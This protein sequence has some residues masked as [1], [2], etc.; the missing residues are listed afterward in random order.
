[1]RI[2]T[3]NLAGRWTPAHAA[4]LT[5]LGCDALLLPEVRHDVALPG[6]RQH[7]SVLEMAPGRHWASIVARNLEA[8]PDPHGASAAARVGVLILCSSVLPWRSA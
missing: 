4:L 5:G 1:M 2:G 8:L 6:M 3:W 7:R